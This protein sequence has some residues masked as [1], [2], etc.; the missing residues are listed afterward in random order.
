MS[1]V[2]GPIGES[3]LTNSAHKFVVFVPSQFERFFRQRRRLKFIFFMPRLTKTKRKFSV[4]SIGV[5]HKFVY[6]FIYPQCASTKVLIL[7]LI[8]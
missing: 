8:F 6:T 3:K 1:C 2:G 4:W 7:F 5:P